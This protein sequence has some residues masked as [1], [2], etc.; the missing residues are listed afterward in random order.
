MRKLIYVPI[1][2]ADPDMGSLAPGLEKWA[3]EVVGGANLEKH[4]QAVDLYWRQLAGYWDKKKVGGA[5]IFQDGMATNGAIGKKIVKELAQKGSVNY[6]IIERLLEKGAELIKTEDPI[7]LKEEYFLTK[8]LLKKKS[9]LGGLLATLRYKWRKDKLLKERDAYIAK[10]INENLKEGEMGICFLGAYHQVLPWLASDI[11]VVPLRNLD[12]I[13]EYYQKFI[14][15]KWEGEVNDLSR[16]Y[17]T[18]PIGV[19]LGKKY[20]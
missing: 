13:K 8:E 16:R 12:R 1:I 6:Q 10:A 7:L 17:L 4:K 5:K 20:D 14:T 9:F 15:Q 2:H 18:A 3:N 11:L 19:L